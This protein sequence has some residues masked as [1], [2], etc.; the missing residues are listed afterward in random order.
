MKEWIEALLVAAV[1]GA[2]GWQVRTLVYQRAYR[3]RLRELEALGFGSTEPS[4]TGEES[5]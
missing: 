3:R 2:L 4:S 1:S 5:K